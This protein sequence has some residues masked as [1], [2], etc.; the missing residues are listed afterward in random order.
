M[1]AFSKVIVFSNAIIWNNMVTSLLSLV[2]WE[3][4]KSIPMIFAM[5]TCR[6]PAVLIS[7]NYYP[8]NLILSVSQI[9]TLGLFI[10]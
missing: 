8:L 1:I 6:A 5:E 7:V 3:H 9:C 10:V 4:Y 2:T